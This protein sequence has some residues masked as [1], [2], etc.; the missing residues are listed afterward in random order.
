MLP[1]LLRILAGGT[2]PVTWV[3]NYTGIVRFYTH[4]N[5]ACGAESLCRTKSVACS[6]PIWLFDYLLTASPYPSATFTPNCTGTA[7]AITTCA[8][9]SE[10]S[11]VNVISGNSY[12]F[13]SSC[14]LFYHHQQCRRNHCF[15]EWAYPC[16]LGVQYY[17]C[18]SFLHPY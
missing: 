17:R 7:E 10:Y 18:C 9:A 3:S 8:Y 12:T 11:N 4:T 15:S 1:E 16:N 5:S 6:V 13:S 2:T 14:R